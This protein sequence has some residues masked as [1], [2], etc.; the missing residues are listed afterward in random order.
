MRGGD[1]ASLTIRQRWV[2]SGAFRL[3]FCGALALLAV[4]FWMGGRV[5]LSDIQSR[6]LEGYINRLSTA[7]GVIDLL[8]SQPPS[9]PGIKVVSPLVLEVQPNKSALINIFF[10]K[11]DV[12]C[13]EVILAALHSDGTL[14]NSQWDYR[15]VRTDVR[16]TNWLITTIPLNQT[17]GKTYRVGLFSDESCQSVKLFKLLQVKKGALENW[18]MPY[19]NDYIS[20]GPNNVFK[21]GL[22]NGYGVMPVK[23]ELPYDVKKYYFPEPLKL[24]YLFRLKPENPATWYKARAE[25]IVSEKSGALVVQSPPT[26]GY[27]IATP[28]FSTVAG[29][30][31]FVVLDADKPAN[32]GLVLGILNPA[33]LRWMSNTPLSKL[34]G[35]KWFTFTATGE[36]AYFIFSSSGSNPIRKFKLR[37]LDVGKKT[38]LPDW[39]INQ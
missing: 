10:A 27:L 6:N 21:P 1:A 29:E 25:V 39:M 17:K 38:A 37:R 11:V 12:S 24:N 19:Y 3:V 31:Y 18:I 7:P 32:Q 14:V 22:V 13:R 26:T 4:V 33:T 20:V 15:Y 16:G 5:Y 9:L 30:E 2:S 34:D 23:L 35:L 28:E 36:R 8:Q